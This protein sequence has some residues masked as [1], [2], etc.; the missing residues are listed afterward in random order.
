MK[1]TRQRQ[2]FAALGIVLA[3]FSSGGCKKEEPAR[4]AKL[5]P[6]SVI[7]AFGDSL[8]WGKGVERKESY[9]AILQVLTRCRV[10]NAGVRGETTAQG[11]ARLP[12]I[13]EKGQPS[14]II[15]C[16]GGNDMLQK[17]SDQETIDNLS[18]MIEF[19]R[20]K[21][22]DVILVGVPRMQLPLET[23]EYYPAL[24]KKHGIPCQTTV[25]KKLLSADVLKS[26]EIHLNEQGYAILAQAI[27]ELIDE[28]QTGE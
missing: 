1:T 24:A 20:A 25:L 27:S 8:T 23:A 4:I 15:L 3:V 14:L 2:T 13:F 10:Y 21:G 12:R 5:G 11:L 6:L 18:K 28:S 16:E 17:K 19:I 22:C 7:V 26:D 9:P